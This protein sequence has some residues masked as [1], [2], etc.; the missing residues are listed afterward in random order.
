MLILPLFLA[1]MAAAPDAA[2]SS[3]APA[4]A[5]DASTAHWDQDGVVGAPDARCNNQ[6]L[7]TDT[8][9]TEGAPRAAPVANNQII[10]PVLRNMG[11]GRTLI[12]FDGVRMPDAPAVAPPSDATPAAPAAADASPASDTVAR[13]LRD[14]QAQSEV[15]TINLN[16]GG[17]QRP[18]WRPG[19]NPEEGLYAPVNKTDADGCP[20][21]TPISVPYGQ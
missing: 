16:S 2:V 10:R 18:L 3:T 21:A 15:R 14:F 1:A 8:P 17:M 13:L 5:G 9:S 6:T 12:L 4:P 7:M 19:E 11:A 20:I